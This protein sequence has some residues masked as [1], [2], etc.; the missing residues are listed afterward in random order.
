MRI[1]TFIIVI[2]VVIVVTIVATILVLKRNGKSTKEINQSWLD[3]I[4]KREPHIN[5]QEEPAQPSFIQRLKKLFQE[6]SKKYQPTNRTR[7]AFIEEEL[8]LRNPPKR[9]FEDTRD[10]I[11]DKRPKKKRGDAK[12]RQKK[13]VYEERCRQILE[14]LF[15]KRFIKTRPAWLRNE[16][17]DSKTGT[18][19]NKKLE[20]D[21]Y[22]EDLNLAFEYNGRQHRVYPNTWHET[23][24]EF[25]DQQ[26]RDRLKKV[27]CEEEG[28]IL[29]VIPDA[30]IVPYNQLYEFITEELERL[31]VVEIE[32]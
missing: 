4:L 17:R 1:L 20:L 26:K 5:K 16:K 24:K 29:V 30:E 27:R 14:K 2:I 25:D 19:T 8:R 22:C 12:E 6:T 28:I 32:D 9:D 10:D 3:T 7:G 23:K 11:E 13:R 18:G 31:G 21:G 15:N